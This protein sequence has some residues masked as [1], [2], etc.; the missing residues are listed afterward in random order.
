MTVVYSVL[1]EHLFVKKVV[2]EL[3][4]DSHMQYGWTSEYEK[5]GQ[6]AFLGY[7]SA[8]YHSIIRMIKLKY[9]NEELGKE[10]NLSKNSRF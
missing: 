8:L 3:S 2:K 5:Y 10:L 1:T 7:G 9:D 4:I 6:S